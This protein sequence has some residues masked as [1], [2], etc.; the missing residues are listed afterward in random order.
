[1]TACSGVVARSHR[2]LPAPRGSRVA[3]ARPAGRRRLGAARAVAAAVAA[4]ACML[5]VWV[6]QSAAQTCPV[7]DLMQDGK[8]VTTGPKIVATG[9]VGRR[10][11]VSLVECPCEAAMGVQLPVGGAGLTVVLY[12]QLLETPFQAGWYQATFYAYIPAGF[13]GPAVLATASLL[14]SG[15]A[16]LQ[17]KSVLR[18]GTYNS[19]L[20][21]P[22]PLNSARMCARASPP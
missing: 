11:V 19:W 22:C 20:Q 9:S 4:A 10:S 3:M 14:D 16:F 2:S 15:G 7:P 12:E 5:G 6:E 17:R 18:G 13:D 21:V 1:M 8:F